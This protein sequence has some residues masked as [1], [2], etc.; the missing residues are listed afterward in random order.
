MGRSLPG[1]RIVV[2]RHLKSGRFGSGDALARSLDRPAA[3][4]H[5]W[6]ARFQVHREGTVVAL[7]GNGYGHGVGLCQTGASVR[8]RRGETE[9]A[10]LG[11]YFP[12]ARIASLHD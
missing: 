11:A 12:D 5:V 4:G 1:G 6:S 9:E 2:V 10:I 3:W 8:A 7:Q